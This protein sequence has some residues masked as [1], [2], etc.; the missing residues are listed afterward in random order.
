MMPMT[1]AQAEEPP[2]QAAAGA[3]PGS[4]MQCRGRAEWPAHAS[5]VLCPRGAAGDWP[6]W[7]PSLS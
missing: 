5:D 7:K 1:V 3:P 6:I 2:R 4:G